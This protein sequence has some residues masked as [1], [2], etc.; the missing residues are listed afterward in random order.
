MSEDFPEYLRGL[1][2]LKGWTSAEVSRRTEVST[3]TVSRWLSGELTPN[4]QS[5]RNI[6]EAFGLPLAEVYRA[7]GLPSDYTPP[8]QPP[9]PYTDRIREALA[10]AMAEAPIAV[11]IHEQSASAG[12]GDEILEYLYLSKAR[13]AGRNI[14]GLKVHGNS[15]EPE[16]QD[17]D[18]IFVDKDMEPH[19][20]S[21]VVASM[22]GSSSDVLFVKWYRRRQGRAVLEGNNGEIDASK[23]RIEGVVIQQSRDRR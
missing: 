18:V 8:D 11:A 10:Y 5:C 19:D 21:I 17:G 22:K 4:A 23:V 20:G 1:M 3:S 9:Q 7:A 14:I 13:A 2:A 15:M 12:M 6:A 16:L